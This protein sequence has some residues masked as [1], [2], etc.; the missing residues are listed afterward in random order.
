MALVG[1]LM[2]GL[3]TSSSRHFL[4]VLKALCLGAKAVGLGRAFLYAQS[5]SNGACVKFIQL[6]ILIGLWRSWCHSFSADPATR[7]QIRYGVS[8]CP[9]SRPTFPRNGEC[10]HSKRDFI[11]SLSTEVERVDWQPAMPARL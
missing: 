9:V 7:N 2:I 4:D 1:G 3:I 8:R 6:I 10:A 5:V 11:L